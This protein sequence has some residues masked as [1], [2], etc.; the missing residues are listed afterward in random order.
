MVGLPERRAHRRGLITPTESWVHRVAERL[1]LTLERAVDAGEVPGGVAVVGTLDSQCLACVGGLTSAL[2]GAATGEH[3]HYDVASL[4]KVMATWPLVGRAQAAGLLDLDAPVGPWFP[5]GDAAPPV[6]LPGAEVTPRRILTHTSRLDPVTDFARYI[7]SGR[8][9]AECILA[10]P[11]QGPGRRYIDR[12]FILLGLLLERVHG[13]S[14]DVIAQELWTEIG[15]SETAYGPVARGAGTAPT[16]R[17]L[18]GAGPAWGVVHD[19][20]TALMGGVAGHAGVFTTGADLGRFARAVLA[21]LQGEP[22]PIPPDFS[23]ESAVVHAPVARGL[24][25]GLAWLV[26]ADGLLHH[27][28]YTGTYLA[29]DP[30]RGRYVGLL[31]NAVHHGRARVGL[32]ALR[33]A[34]RSAVRDRPPAPPAGRGPTSASAA[35]SH[36]EQRLSPAEPRQ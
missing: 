20:S 21:G 6:T 7:G 18:A 25:Q 16:E 14:L 10:E 12:G 11:L 36:R 4:T 28:G 24:G 15:L 32:D 27:S 2:P 22:G 17:R 1:G 35:G 34:V 8:T 31:T 29:V 30:G 19:E 9:L 23:R 5:G 13:C 3:V 33:R 26:E